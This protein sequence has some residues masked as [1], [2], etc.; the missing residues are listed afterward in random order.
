VNT[1]IKRD[2]FKNILH[3]LAVSQQSVEGCQKICGWKKRHSL[4]LLS[5]MWAT[6]VTEQLQP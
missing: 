4:L 3:H 1:S 6:V 2:Q 5:D